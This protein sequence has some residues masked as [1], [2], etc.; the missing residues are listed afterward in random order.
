MLDW[1]IL[2]Y[3]YQAIDNV[4]RVKYNSSIFPGD[5]EYMHTWYEKF[6]IFREKTE[7]F[8]YDFTRGRLNGT[9]D[10]PVE[11]V[12]CFKR[13]TKYGHDIL[14]KFLLAKKALMTCRFAS[15]FILVF[16]YYL[17]SSSEP[18]LR[19]TNKS[20]VPFTHPGHGLIAHVMFDADLLPV[21]FNYRKNIY[22]MVIYYYKHKQSPRYQRI[23][24][25]RIG[26]GYLRE[27]DIAGVISNSYCRA[28]F[29]ILKEQ[30]QGGPKAE[31]G[32]A[33]QCEERVQN[34]DENYVRKIHTKILFERNS[35]WNIKISA[36]SDIFHLV[37]SKDRLS[38]TKY[39]VKYK[40][41]E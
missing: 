20:F 28:S 21:V 27:T 40:R 25:Y 23:R 12:K 9:F 18:V 17:E 3:G 33:V 15:N 10:L 39:V 5:L 14:L 2:I 34:A 13:K 29:L 36:Q 16:D 26:L 11:V 24:E 37:R 7:C 35:G 8:M 38:N 31:L 6:F 4:Y 1:N 32:F 22:S 19:L 41:D 30:S